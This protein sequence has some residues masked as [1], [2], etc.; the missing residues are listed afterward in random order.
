MSPSVWSS[1]VTP[2]A[3]SAS[4]CDVFAAA[5][6]LISP[7]NLSIWSGLVRNHGSC[8]TRALQE[9]ASC[10]LVAQVSVIR[11]ARAYDVFVSLRRVAS[12]KMIPKGSRETIGGLDGAANAEETGA[13]VGVIGTASAE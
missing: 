3:V 10:F 13:T 4:A 6:V 2:V 9:L 11:P 5:P 8:R 12:D 1:F 7:S